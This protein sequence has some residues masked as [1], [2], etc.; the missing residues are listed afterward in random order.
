MLS[1]CINKTVNPGSHFYGKIEGSP[2]QHFEQPFKMRVESDDLPYIL[3]LHYCHGS[4]ISETDPLIKEP[5]KQFPCLLQDDPI[6]GYHLD[7]R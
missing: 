3:L 6:N 1:L 2:T 5:E 7:A 4:C